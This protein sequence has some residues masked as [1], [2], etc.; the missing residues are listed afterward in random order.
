MG[1]RLKAWVH[2][3]LVAID[4]V[5]FLRLRCL[6]FVLADNGDQPS[7]YETISSFTG[8][9]ANL[10][11]PWAL[12]W[13]PRIDWLFERLGSPPGHCQRSIVRADQLNAPL[14]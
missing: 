1:A 7:P 3:Y 13:Q 11:V 2:A 6:P 8:R 5:W 10:A 14:P 12:R 9:M 4:A